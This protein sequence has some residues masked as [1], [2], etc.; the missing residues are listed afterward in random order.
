MHFCQV[1][2]A[3]ARRLLRAKGGSLRAAIGD[4]K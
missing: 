1:G 2:C 4:A 3:D